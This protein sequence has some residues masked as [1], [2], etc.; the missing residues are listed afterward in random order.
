M[1]LQ[2]PEKGTIWN[3]VGGTGDYEVVDLV[4]VV[5]V[6]AEVLNA[7]DHAAGVLYR[8]PANGYRPDVLRVRKLDSFLADFKPKPQP[9][10]TEETVLPVRRTVDGKVIGISGRAASP[11]AAPHKD[12]KL[13]IRPDGTWTGEWL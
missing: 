11:D 4:E 7:T 3:V 13:T 6:V 5:E 10:I 12:A 9:V 8:P 1:T 2:A